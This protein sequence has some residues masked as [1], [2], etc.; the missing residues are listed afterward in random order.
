MKIKWTT[1]QKQKTKKV[2]NVG[3]LSRVSQPPIV[4]SFDTIVV[5]T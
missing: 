4:S 3:G 1:Q 5:L 2:E